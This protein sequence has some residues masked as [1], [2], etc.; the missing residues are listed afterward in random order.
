MVD[1]RVVEYLREGIKRG[2]PV[3]LLKEKLIREG[4]YLPSEVEEAW[5]FVSTSMHEQHAESEGKKAPS[6]PLAQVKHAHPMTSFKAGSV[7]AAAQASNPSEEYISAST[8]IEDANLLTRIR[9]AFLFPSKLFEAAAR[10][11][12]AEAIKFYWL[13]ALIPSLLFV[14]V[15]ALTPHTLQNFLSVVFPFVKWGFL[16]SLDRISEIL[17]S[18][19]V[20]LIFFLVIG[21]L[22]TFVFSGLIHA[23]ILLFKKGARFDSTFNVVVYSLTPLYFLAII[24]PV[25]FVW[26]VVLKLRGLEHVHRLH[27]AKVITSWLLAILTGGIIW[28]VY[29]YIF[30]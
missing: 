3:Q 27:L 5:K 8:P 4:G 2:Y 11:E 23:F 16:S 24:F 22:A 28:L 18:V 10:D 1:E 19:P 15:S 21:L 17:L 30:L 6:T 29:V 26:T 9:F 20:A 13:I 12:R 25:G 7:Q 14:L